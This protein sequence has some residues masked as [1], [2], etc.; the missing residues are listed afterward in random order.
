MFFIIQIGQYG[1][2]VIKKMGLKTENFKH[3]IMR[4]NSF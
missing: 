2:E 3:L 4:V 1:V